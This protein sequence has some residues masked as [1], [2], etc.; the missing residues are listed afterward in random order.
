[1]NCVLIVDSISTNIGKKSQING[2]HLP[3]HDNEHVKFVPSV[4]KIRHFSP[5]PHGGHL[6]EHFNG[7]EG[8][9][10]VVEILENFTAE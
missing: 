1:M 7:E 10:E 8:E 5:E 4:C 2:S 9:D 3:S 6:D